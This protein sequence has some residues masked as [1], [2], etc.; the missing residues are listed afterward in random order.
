M[1]HSAAHWDSLYKTKASDAVSWYQD[2][3]SVSL[4]LL[5]EEADPGA[6]VFDVGGGTSFLPDYLLDGGW[7][8]VTVLDV[9]DTALGEVRQRLGSRGASVVLL[10]ADLLAW[11]PA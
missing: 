3:P 5:R 7:A 1:V 2:E 6:P 9:P 11:Q 10:T 8:D 4:R